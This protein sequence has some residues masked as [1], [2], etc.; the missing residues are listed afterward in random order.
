MQPQGHFQMISAMIDDDL[1][2]Q[3]AL[4]RPCWM[5][6][7]GY[8]DSELWLEEGLPIKIMARLAEYGH[9]ARPISGYL[10]HGAFGDGQIIRRDV[11]TSVLYVGS[12]PRKDGLPAEW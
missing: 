10:L 3:E 1:N 6:E 9:R 5:L 4:N 11:E 7:S 8:G 2:P 12:D